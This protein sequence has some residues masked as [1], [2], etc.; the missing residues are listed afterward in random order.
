MT[1][2][3]AIANDG[4]LLK[5]YIIKEVYNGD[6]LLESSTEKKTVRQVISPD[7]AHTLANMMEKVISEGGGQ[8]AA[9]KGYRFAGKTGTAERLKE[10]GGGYEA[11][12]YIAS[13]VGFGPVE[14]PQVAAADCD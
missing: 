5:P 6:G 2:V 14:N 8:K 9:I 1:A 12:H 10:G 7:T 3:C 11:N 4:V 13:F